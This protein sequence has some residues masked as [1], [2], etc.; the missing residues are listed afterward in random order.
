MSRQV[1]SAGTNK[2]GLLWGSGVHPKHDCL[3]STQILG[4]QEIA[5]ATCS[6]FRKDLLLSLHD[7]QELRFVVEHWV[8]YRGNY[9]CPTEKASE[10]EDVLLVHG[11]QGGD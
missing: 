9:A 8:Y 6:S 5:R 10:V 2:T 7:G 3:L 11:A 1:T 4:N